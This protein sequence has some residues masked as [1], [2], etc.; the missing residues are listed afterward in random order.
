MGKTDLRIV[1]TL[2]QIDRSLLECLKSCPFQKITVDML[3]KHALINRSTFYKYYLDKYD[4]LDKYIC[5]TL[6]EFRENI[7]V[8]FINADP[9]NIHDISYIRNFKTALEF[10]AGK[11]EVYEILWNTTLDIQIFNEMTRIVHDNILAALL[12][13][14]D[15]TLRKEKYEDLYAH[16][17]ASNMMS[18]V[19]WWFKYYDSVS[20]KNVEDI[21][22]SNMH[23]GLFRTFKMQLN[24]KQ[25]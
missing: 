23:L 19:L 9:S 20:M 16:L 13:M 6:D 22:T 15:R 17:F 7:N 24:E 14:T 3:C 1:K 4:L 18:L 11:K 10:I 12:P 25:P 2:H 21:M 5:R 8:E